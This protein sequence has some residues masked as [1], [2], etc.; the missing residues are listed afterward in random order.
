MVQ[1]R[2]LVFE[3]D[4]VHTNIIAFHAR[5]RGE[6][7]GRAELTIACVSM[8]LNSFLVPLSTNNDRFEEASDLG[9]VERIGLGGFSEIN[10]AMKTPASSEDQ[11]NRMESA[12]FPNLSPRVYSFISHYYGGLQH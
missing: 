9:I 2:E 3:L 1:N 10:T 12:S 7:E 11:S 6:A 5:L 8:K 4:G